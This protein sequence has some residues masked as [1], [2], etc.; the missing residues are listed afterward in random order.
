MGVHDY[1]NT[2][3]KQISFRKR[4][5]ELTRDRANGV[6]VDLGLLLENLPLKTLFMNHL[7]TKFRVPI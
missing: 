2:D 6:L 1:I 3:D 5:M 4:S 7:R